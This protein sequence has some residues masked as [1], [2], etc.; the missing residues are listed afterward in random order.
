MAKRK[1]AYGSTKSAHREDAG[2]HLES[3]RHRAKKVRAELARGNCIGAF[4]QL[5]MLNRLVGKAQRELSHAKRAGGS[6]PR[7]GD[8]VYAV[9][10]SLQN[11]WLMKCMR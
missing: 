9:A 3:A 10:K 4:D 6:V 7:G 11:K 8:S 1:R 5:G 2:A